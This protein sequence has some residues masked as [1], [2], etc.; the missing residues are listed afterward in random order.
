VC[1]FQSTIYE[2]LYNGTLCGPLSF[3]VFVLSKELGVLVA[4]FGCAKVIFIIFQAKT[5]L[6]K[7][8]VADL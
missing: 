8:D 1:N 7:H 6:K 5:L 4:A 3:G 2:K